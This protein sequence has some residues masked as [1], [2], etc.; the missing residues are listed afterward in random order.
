MYGSIYIPKKYLE[1][2]NVENLFSH[3]IIQFYIVMKWEH[4]SLFEDD[5]YDNIFVHFDTFFDTLSTL[6]GR[7]VWL[8]CSQIYLE[9]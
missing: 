1:A 3:I 8:M 7:L 5:V 2:R 6:S 9:L 4:A